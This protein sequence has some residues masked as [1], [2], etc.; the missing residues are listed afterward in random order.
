[1]GKSWRNTL[2]R[3]GVLSLTAFIVFKFLFLPVR[4]SGPSMEP[5]YKDGSINFINTL[6]SR[7]QAPQRGD[8]VAI[9][10]AGRHIML[11]KRIIGLPGE[12]LKFEKGELVVND[13]IINEPYLKTECDWSLE[14]VLI[15]EN[16]FFVTGDNRGM[17]LDA[18]TH[19]RVSK[20]R[21]VGRA[22]F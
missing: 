10:M 2:I 22:L 5:A 11:F 19:G 14:E 16:D 18:H 12:R 3:A 8:V 4:I 21:I 13:E 20:E 1:M 15:G 6:Y 9:R 17:A 7:F